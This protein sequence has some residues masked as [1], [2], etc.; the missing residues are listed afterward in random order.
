MRFLEVNE[1]LG[2]DKETRLIYIN[3]EDISHFRVY[4]YNEFDYN[5]QELYLKFQDK[6]AVLVSL[7]SNRHFNIDSKSGEN[8]FKALAHRIDKL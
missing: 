7:K 3:I 6:N 2:N 4:N 8:L 1:Y 5:G